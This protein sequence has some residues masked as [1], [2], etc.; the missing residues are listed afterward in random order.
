MKSLTTRRGFL[1]RAAATA[2]TGMLTAVP[3]SV[4]AKPRGAN[5]DIRIAIVGLNGHGSGDH[6]KYL[7]IPGVRI[8]ALC[9]PDRNALAKGVRIVG[10]K[11]PNLRTYTDI[12]KLLEANDIDAISGATPNHWHALSTVWACQAGKHVCVE[13]PVSHNIWE[14]RKMV[15]AAAKYDRLVQADLDLRSDPAMNQAIDYLHNGTLGKIIFVHSWVYKRRGSIGQVDGAG[16]VPDSV[17]YDLWCGPAPKVPLP[18]K[19]LHYDWHW[20]W[21]YG[22]GEIGNNGPHFLDVCRWAL[23][24]D[25]LPRSVISFGGRYGYVDDGQTPNTQITLYEGPL[26]PIL[27][28]VRGLARSSNDKRMDPYRAVSRGGIGLYS[29][30]D[31]GAPNNGAIVVCEDGYVDLNKKFAFDRQGKQI[32]A[33]VAKG[34]SAKENFIRALRSGRTSDLRTTIVE[35]HLSSSICHMGNISYRIGQAASIEEVN[36]VIKKDDQA[37]DALERTKDHLAANGLDLAQ[38]GVTLGPKLTM[39]A[40]TEHFVGPFA[41]AANTLVKREYREPFVIRD[42]V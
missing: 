7:H 9:D 38:E 14:G 21:D 30:H 23:G 13:K 2:A 19:R 6:M 28:E 29:A 26:A 11:T 40:M 4:W 31:S 12:R 15:E 33:F 27:F 24:M 37:L 18:R 8:V 42:E 16:K 41:D 5:D 32:K 22:C 17:D 1:Q 36:D 10:D 25:C 20:Q 3:R 34:R 35:G 39:D